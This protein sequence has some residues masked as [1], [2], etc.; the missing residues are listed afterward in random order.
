MFKKSMT[1]LYARVVV[2]MCGVNIRLYPKTSFSSKQ[3]ANEWA[4]AIVLLF[5]PSYEGKAESWYMPG[6]NSGDIARMLDSCFV[7]YSQ[8]KFV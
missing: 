8:D 2:R 6:T 5:Y 7:S 4:L 1:E 3:E